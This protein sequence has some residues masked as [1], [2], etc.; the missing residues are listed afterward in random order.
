M[1]N[2]ETK[3]DSKIS[4]KTP[5]I[6]YTCCVAAEIKTSLKIFSRLTSSR[7]ESRQRYSIFNTNIH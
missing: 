1:L 7:L 2:Y 4:L 3:A 5:C 6:Q